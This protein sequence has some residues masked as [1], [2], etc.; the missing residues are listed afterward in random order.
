MLEFGSLMTDRSFLQS[1]VD[2]CL[3][4]LGL[5]KDYL[6]RLNPFGHSKRQTFAKRKW[7][8]GIRKFASVNN[9]VYIGSTP[10]AFGLKNLKK[11][12]INTIV[13]LRASLD[14]NIE[15]T[16]LGFQYFMIP[17]NGK[18]P[19][20]DEQIIKFLTVFKNNENLPT[21]K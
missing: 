4:P 10:T 19:P 3:L 20:E 18:R 6:R 1:A 21:L 8:R 16:K 7:L 17:L 13:N 9:G 14:Y 11:I 15:A 2:S 5:A 12:G